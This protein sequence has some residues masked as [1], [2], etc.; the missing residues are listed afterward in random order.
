MYYGLVCIGDLQ[1]RFDADP[2]ARLLIV[3]VEQLEPLDGYNQLCAID[4][5]HEAAPRH[6]VL[7]LQDPD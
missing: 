3:R 2:A 6:P 4:D 5:T 1:I 7:E